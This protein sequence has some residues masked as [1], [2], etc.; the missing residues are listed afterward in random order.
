MEKMD[1]NLARAFHATASAGSL[2]A[3][4]RLIGLTQPTLSRQVAALETALGVT[5]FERLGKKLVLTETGI[6]LLD[7]VKAMAEA[8]DG[9][10]L[11]ASGQATAIEGQVSISAT[12]GYCAYLMPDI[13]AAIRAAV[14]QVTLVVIASNSITDLRRR[15]AD[16]AIRHVDPK[17]PDLIA[18]KVGD[19]AAH[20]YAAA[21]WVARHGM[22]QGIEDIRPA[23][24]IAYDGA[25]RFAEFMRGIGLAVAR[26]DFRLVSENSVVVWEMVKRGHGIGLMLREIAERTPGI[27]R[28]LPE[29]KAVPVPI[30]LVTHREL[31]TSR[32]IRLV[33]DLLADKLARR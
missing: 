6:G 30:W 14:P 18:R 13:L 21:A 15:E 20:F 4:A 24:L 9:L 26:D 33:F 16:I 7:H 17:E 31:H 5:L 10:A 8:A 2:S 22:P 29:V 19:T 25:G 1:W 3:A 28:L 32:R 12:D 23:D 27:V 11:A